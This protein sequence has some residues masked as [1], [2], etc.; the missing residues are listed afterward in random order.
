[1]KAKEDQISQQT[2][3][4]PRNSPDMMEFSGVKK[5]GVLGLDPKCLSCTG[6]AQPTIISSFKLACL[7]YSP[8]SITYRGCPFERQSLMNMQRFLLSQCNSLVDLQP[9]FNGSGLSTK[10]LFDDLQLYYRDRA[11]EEVSSEFLKSFNSPVFSSLGG[12]A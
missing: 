8:G 2:N 4:I 6:Q 9:P 5:K 7:A 1:L 3:G 12:G 10:K 11:P